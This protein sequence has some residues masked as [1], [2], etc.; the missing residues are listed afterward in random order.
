[1][2]AHEYSPGRHAHVLGTEPTGLALLWHGRGIDQGRAMRPIAERVAARGVLAVS[3][4]WSSEQADRG[5]GDLLASWG[6]ARELA[7]RHR[8][9]PDQIVIAGWS[10][11]AT[12]A[13][14]LVSSG[15]APAP[16]AIVLIA[17]GDGPRVAS[18]ITGQPL[19]S[20]FGPDQHAVPVSL[21]YGEHDPLSTPDLVSGLE[22][23]L[24]AAGWTTSLHVVDADHA[25]VVGARF[26]ARTERY[27]PSRDER[28]K[29]AA[30]T[31]ADLIVS[32]TCASC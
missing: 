9:D 8:L 2:A 5:R 31:V 1:M 32:A 13:L 28:A 27:L 29:V 4:D 23:R 24:R 20:S 7:V 11:G 14:D 12:A 19:P 30:D 18:P 6:F 26:D 15:V 3:I 22:L 16:R 17:P 10:L 21:V 25:G